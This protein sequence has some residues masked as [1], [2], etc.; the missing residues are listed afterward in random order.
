MLGGPGVVG[1]SNGS[2]P[3]SCDHF[4]SRPSRVPLLAGIH[5]P[6]LEGD[7]HF[8]VIPVLGYAGRYSKIKGPEL[9]IET[10]H[11]YK[12]HYSSKVM[13]YM[14][15]EGCSNKNA[16]LTRL[17]EINN[18][19]MNIRLLGK[20]SNIQEFY[21]RIDIFLLTSYAEAFPNVLCEACLQSCL[22]VST[23]VGDVPKILTDMRQ[24]APSP[25][26]KSLA[27]SIQAINSLSIREK[28]KLR[29]ENYL[30]VARSYNIDL[31]SQ[32]LDNIIHDIN[33][34]K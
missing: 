12:Q 32:N 17:I 20:V 24:I 27:S 18:L 22:C 34:E 2:L 23:N 9:F 5:E 25:T 26:A 4:G 28:N 33:N 30:H 6:I 7:C 19:S 16:E 21:K 1:P 31:Y 10:V 11:Y 8:L 3:P 14:C 29:Y 13:A 15:G